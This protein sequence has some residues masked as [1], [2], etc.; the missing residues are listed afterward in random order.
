M[1]NKTLRAF[2]ECLILAILLFGCWILY[3][4]V[5][6]FLLDATEEWQLALLRLA[7]KY[8]AYFLPVVA[9]ASLLMAVVAG[10]ALGYLVKRRHLLYAILLG[11]PIAAFSIA[12]VP[13]QY[14]VSFGVLTALVVVLP[15]AAAGHFLGRALAS[16]PS[17]IPSQ[18]IKSPEAHEVSTVPG[19]IAVLSGLLILT[20]VASVYVAFVKQSESSLFATI[21]ILGAALL[22]LC[23]AVDLRAMR[24]RAVVF[25][26]AAVV[27]LYLF[28]VRATGPVSWEVLAKS[29]PLS[30]AF[31]T[32]SAIYWKRL[33]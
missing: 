8:A 2:D 17:P 33:H 18:N 24:R 14:L 9:P 16:R 28:A 32:I 26:G 11:L 4:N 3:F 10:T 27:G 15:L 30:L 29:I 1:R 12:Y 31:V 7:G 19:A 20:S 13:T 5:S 23:A 22:S 21:G 6:G 25:Y